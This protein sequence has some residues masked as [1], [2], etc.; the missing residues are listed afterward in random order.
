MGH[1]GE[2]QKKCRRLPDAQDWQALDAV[3]LPDGS[4]LEPYVHK[5]LG[6]AAGLAEGRQSAP[7]GERR[8]ALSAGLQPSGG[9]VPT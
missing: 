2:P 9:R 6:R 8:G 1:T 4:M 3:K 5:G 7:Y